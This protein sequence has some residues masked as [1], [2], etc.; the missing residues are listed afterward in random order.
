VFSKA[1][2]ADKH[3]L[4]LFVHFTCFVQRTDKIIEYMPTTLA[5]PRLPLNYI[6][7]SIL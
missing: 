7:L 1:K 4:A 6:K 2:C 3:G 5:L